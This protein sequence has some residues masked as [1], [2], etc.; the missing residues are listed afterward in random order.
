MAGGN[1]IKIEGTF[2]GNGTRSIT[3]PCNFYPDIIYIDLYELV[4]GNKYKGNSYLLN[5]SGYQKIAS[6]I[7]FYIK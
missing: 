1:V 2:S 6:L 7:E 3:I 5:T 4:K